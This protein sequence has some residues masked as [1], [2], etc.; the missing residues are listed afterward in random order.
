MKML[1]LG[2]GAWWHPDW[3]NFD[4]E[5]HAP[6]VIS[7]DLSQGIPFDADSVDV[8]YSSHVLEHL[9]TSEA[10]TFL[11]EQYRVLKPGGVVRVVVPDLEQICRLYLSYLDELKAGNLESE[12]KYDYSLLEMFDQTTRERSGG[13]LRSVW[14]SMSAEDR[15]YAVARHGKEIEGALAKANAASAGGHASLGA[16]T[17][18]R[19][20]SAGKVLQKGRAALGRAAVRL[21]MGKRGLSAFREGMF[22]SSGEIHRVMYDSFR[23]RRLL[24]SVGFKDITVCQAEESRIPSFSSYQLDTVGSS[25]RKPDSLFM[26]AVK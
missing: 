21:L 14:N 22:R 11:R 10:D 13:Q 20:P 7:H 17:R 5:S 6:E 4:L 1:N 19:R 12:F 25:V 18:A 26:E 2:C 9:R 16:Q 15:S 8:C 3:I 24:S 23:L